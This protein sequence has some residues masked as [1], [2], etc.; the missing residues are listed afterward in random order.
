MHRTLIAVLVF[1][2]IVSSL[3]VLTAD[4]PV[5]EHRLPA[6]RAVTQRGQRALEAMRRARPD[7][8]IESAHIQG[9]APDFEVNVVVVNRGLVAYEP[10]PRENYRPVVALWHR[11]GN[12]LVRLADTAQIPP[13]GRGENA[14]VT[15]GIS[16]PNEGSARVLIQWD[17]DARNDSTDLHWVY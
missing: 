4:A 1:T 2:L 10:D 9:T 17:A 11:V 5:F 12:D 14:T 3:L 13:L 6:D 15:L 16:M 8:A 7:L